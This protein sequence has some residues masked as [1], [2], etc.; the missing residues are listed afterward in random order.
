[1]FGFIIRV[2]VAL[3]ALGFN[4]YLFMSGSWGW[5]ISLILVTALIFLSFWRNEN[6]IIALYHMRFGKQDKAWK[7]L[8]RLKSLNYLPKGQRAYVYYLKA[9]LGMQHE[10]GLSNCEQ[11]MRKALSIGLRTK[12]DRAVAHLQL[13]G[14]AMQTGRKGEAKREMAEAKKLD[15]KDI[16]KEQLQQMRKQMGMVASKNQMRMAQMQRGRV[17]T[18][19]RRGN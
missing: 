17:K 16:L 19:R 5:G 15:E 6:V 1:M 13:A 8:N 7:S 2:I 12:Q 10:M 18:P 3:S 11:M 14:I 9:M 4:T